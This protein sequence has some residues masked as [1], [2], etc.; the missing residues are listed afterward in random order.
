MRPALEE[1]CIKNN[2]HGSRCLVRPTYGALN[3]CDS[4]QGPFRPVARTRHGA[5]ST[6]AFS[7]GCAPCWHIR[8]HICRRIE[9]VSLNCPNGCPTPPEAAVRG[10]L[11]LDGLGW[12]IAATLSNG[13]GNSKAI[14]S[15]RW[16][17]AASTPV[18]G[19]DIGFIDR[20]RQILAHE[21]LGAARSVKKVRS[22]GILRYGLT[23]KGIF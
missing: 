18:L 13:D 6:W 8:K 20:N 17:G 5:A 16:N 12:H 4:G 21:A 22:K 3:T 1:S 14:M 19:H 7:P 2:L 11:T 23:R 9:S 10:E 15:S